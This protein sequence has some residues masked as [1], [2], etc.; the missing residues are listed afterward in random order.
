MHLKYLSLCLF[1]LGLTACAQHGVRPQ[2]AS[3]SLEQKA[4]QSV[5]A[6]YEYPSYDYRGNFKITVDPSQIKQ[7]VKAENTAKLDAE[8]QKKVDQYLREQKVALSKA[9]KQT[10]YAAIAN[11]QGDLGLTSSARSEK[12]NTV[13]FNLLN[14]L[15]FSYDGSIH[16]RQKMGS[17]NLTARYEKPTLLVQA[18]LP[19]VLDLENYKFYINYFGLMP[20]LVNKDNQ[21][22]LAYV[23]FSK[24]KAFFKNVDKKKFIEYL[25]ASSAVS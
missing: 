25:K 23:D 5:N 11:E 7:N 4:I 17:F 21:N 9:Q 10:L 18:K 6:M 19:M 3:A 14:D 20:Y 24:Y 8:L 22:N 13:L 1:S 2:V 16:Y 12:I 15:Q